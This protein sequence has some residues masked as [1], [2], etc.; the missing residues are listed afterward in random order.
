MIQP[1][2]LRRDNPLVLPQHRL[3]YYQLPDGQMVP[4]E[5]GG[6][7]EFA[8]FELGALLIDTTAAENPGSSMTLN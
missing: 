7:V 5:M 8:M 3:V 2:I 1:L 4:V 6:M